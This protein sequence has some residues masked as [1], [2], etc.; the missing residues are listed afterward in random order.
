MS[1]HLLSGLIILPLIGSLFILMMKSDE[2]GLRNI[3]WIA[4]FTTLATFILSLV[5]WNKFD[6]SSAAFQ[7]VEE[8]SWL[9]DKI[10]FKLGVR[11]LP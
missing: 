2:A 5:A 4:L 1:S 10:T 6:P 7:L 8:S 9:S 11:I 3:R